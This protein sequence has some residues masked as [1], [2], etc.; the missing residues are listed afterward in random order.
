MAT[1]ILSQR[2]EKKEELTTLKKIVVAYDF[3]EAA[4]RA[5]TDAMAL[6]RRFQAALILAHAEV[7]RKG[8]L[9]TEKRALKDKETRA[10]LSA[11]R[12]R[13]AAGGLECRERTRSG[14]VARVLVGIAEDEDADLLLIGAYGNGPK[15]RRTL[16][17]TAE[18][19]LRSLRC[20]IMIYGPEAFKP[21][22][23]DDPLDLLV[24]IEFLANSHSLALAVNAS[25]LL[26]ARVDILHVVDVRKTPSMPEAALDTQYNCEL[27][28]SYL[29]KEGLRVSQS[30]LFG[31][32]DLVII[33]R[34]RE[35][36]SSLILLPLGSR[37]HLT[38]D[39]VAASVVR[40]AAV[41]VMTCRIDA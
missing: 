12:R 5:L 30:L 9:H 40:N 25:K 36:H 27:V 37:E 6:S 1:Q 14:D 20:P 8:I 23:Q 2:F 39:N 7:P 10:D 15:D 18:K 24:P 4:D 28:A 11:L 38:S 22:F 41:P 21:A 26:H 31:R 35:M 13:V 33:E 19:L 32:P 29:R 3:S 34:S 17:S 16:G